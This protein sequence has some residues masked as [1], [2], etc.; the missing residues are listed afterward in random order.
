MLHSACYTTLVRGDAIT[1]DHVPRI[2][3]RITRGGARLWTTATRRTLAR[4]AM[5]QIHCERDAKKVKM[6]GQILKGA[7]VD[8]RASIGVAGNAA[9]SE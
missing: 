5:F 4:A 3:R 9:Q 8:V 7:I 1:M 6:C 2:S